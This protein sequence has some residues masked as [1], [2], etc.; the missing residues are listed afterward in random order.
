MAQNTATTTSPYSQYGLGSLNKG[1]LPQTKAMGGISTAINRISGYNTINVLNP[2][3]YSAIN[4]TSIDIGVLGT[5]NTLQQGNV[6][7][8]RNGNVRLSHFNFAAP[9]SKRSAL[10]FGLVPYSELG[11]NYRNSGTVDT[12]SINYIYSGDG[13]LSKA[14][15]GYGF[16]IGRHLSFGANVSYI[17]GNL[18]KFRSAEIPNLFG[19]INTRSE[20]SNS[21][22]GINFDYGTQVSF[23]LSET[24]HLTFGYSGSANSSLNSKVTNVVTQYRVFDED[25]G[26]AIDTLSNQNI[27]NGKIKLPLMHHVGIS[28]QKDG[29]FL[30]GADYS[31]GSWSKAVI[32]GETSVLQ[33]SQ[34]FNIG[35]QF[36]PN[37]NSLRSYLALVDY[38]LGARYEKTNMRISNT[39][40]KEYALTFGLGLPLP[41]NGGAFYKVNLAGEYGQRGTLSNNLIKENFFTVHIGFTLND[42]WFNRYKF[43]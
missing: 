9:V 19:S 10:S 34:S 36:T 25:E 11:Y 40:I 18:R 15:A 7:G 22:G 37:N 41:R 32:P 30:I 21:V 24:K 2:A 12:N 43:D 1:L 39:D 17:F 5:F 31:L 42:T 28:Y 4:L 13:G 35:G 26:S 29:K 8:Q 38:R 33:D 6:T 16:G 3:S 20:R 14:Y 27:A 23:D